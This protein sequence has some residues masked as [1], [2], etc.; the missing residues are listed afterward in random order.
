MVSIMSLWLPIL[1]SAVLVFVVSSIL[2][3]V[4]PYHRTD[5]A[6]VPQE[7]QVMEALRPL[8]IPPGEYAFPYP[9]NP[10]AMKEPEFMNKLAQG[11][12][13]FMT[14]M[15]N[16]PPAMGKSLALWFVYCAVVG[17]FAAFVAGS[18]LGPGAGMGLVFHYAAVVSFAGYALALL[19]NSI[20]N[21]RSWVVTAKSVFDGLVYAV[22]TGVTFGWLWPG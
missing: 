5:F 18:A 6:K 17:V 11:P 19:Q 16:G 21:R 1:L 8:G 4:L 2:H 13:A 9:D 14:V 7:A 3:M 10:K 22:V 20:W 15:E 12:V